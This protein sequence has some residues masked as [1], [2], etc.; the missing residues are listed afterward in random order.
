MVWCSAHNNYS[1]SIWK[2]LNFR[3]QKLPRIWSW[4][5]KK[6]YSNTYFNKFIGF[7]SVDSIQI[8]IEQFRISA[9]ISIWFNSCSSVLQSHSIK[10]FCEIHLV[11][12][13]LLIESIIYSNYTKC[14]LLVCLNN[15]LIR[16]FH[17]K[18]MA[19]IKSENIN[20]TQCFKFVNK[21]KLT[22]YK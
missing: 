22:K 2:C 13:V 8:F 10:L 18:V 16:I 17:A 6:Q 4:F 1:K 15:Q 11:N 3:T 19:R 21:E 9:Y 14:A 12:M 5:R 20:L 7:M